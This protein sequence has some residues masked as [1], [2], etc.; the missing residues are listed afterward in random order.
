MKYNNGLI[1]A[2]PV[3][4]FVIIIFCF[5]AI[6]FWWFSMRPEQ[7]AIKHL[8]NVLLDVDTAKFS[9]VKRGG[10]SAWPV[11]CGSVNSKNSFGAYVG[12]NRFIINEKSGRV[13]AWESDGSNIDRA[14]NTFC[15]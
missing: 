8:S 6:A 3:C 11:L 12:F 2:R 4:F 1:V 7:E 13:L 10:N 5:L 9:N 15:K 14:W